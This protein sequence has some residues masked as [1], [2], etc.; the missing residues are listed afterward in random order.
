M[1]FAFDYARKNK[2]RKVTA[3]HKANIMKHTDGLFLAVARQVAEKNKDVEFTDS[4]ITDRLL[5]SAVREVY[6]RGRPIGADDL[7]ALASEIEP[8]P[9]MGS[10]HD[11]KA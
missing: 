11:E 6:H 1:Q 3:V 7:I 9:L 4:D 8:S 5:P 2:R 10:G